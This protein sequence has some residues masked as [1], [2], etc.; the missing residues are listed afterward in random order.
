MHFIHILE[1]GLSWKIF[2][3]YPQK[4]FIEYFSEIFCLSNKKFYRKLPAQMTYLTGPVP[5]YEI[6]DSWN[7]VV[8][9]FTRATDH[10]Q[11]S[12]IKS[13]CFVEPVPGSSL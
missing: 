5:W 1:D 6:K 11:V 2:G 10:D 9:Y 7:H 8:L 3:Y 13:A 12:F 4:V